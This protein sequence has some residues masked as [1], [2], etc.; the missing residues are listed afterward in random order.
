MLD[1]ELKVED[2]LSLQPV[3]HL[4]R[5][6]AGLLAGSCCT[7][8]RADSRRASNTRFNIKILNCSIRLRHWDA[9]V[10]I[11]LSYLF[12]LEILAVAYLLLDLIHIR[13][14]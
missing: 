9:T 6:T 7:E 2:Y 4:S 12:V 8:G 14:L 13:H 3:R 10:F 11:E 1:V 5:I